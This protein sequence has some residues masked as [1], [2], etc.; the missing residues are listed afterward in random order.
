MIAELLVS[1]TAVDQNGAAI[2]RPGVA[3]DKSLRV[4]GSF[5]RHV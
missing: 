1:S 2:Q 3:P 4:G 5:R